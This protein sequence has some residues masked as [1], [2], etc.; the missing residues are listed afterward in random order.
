MSEFEHLTTDDA[1]NV[2]ESAIGVFD[3]LLH[4]VRELSKKK[5]DATLSKSK[6]KLINTVLNDLLKILKDEP[7]GKYL[8]A[9]ED[10][11]LPQVSDALMMMVQFR[12]ASV[13][14]RSKYHKIVRNRFISGEFH[15]ITKELLDSWQP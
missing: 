7:E 6:V 5:P 3:A 11:N 4:E 2:Y 13:S 15:W 10:E 14:F 12:A 8:E 1:V 9:L